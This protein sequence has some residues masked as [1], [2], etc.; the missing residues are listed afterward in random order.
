MAKKKKIFVVESCDEEEAQIFE[1]W[2][3][4]ETKDEAIEE[5]RRL[6]GE[7]AVVC[8]ARPLA[9]ERRAMTLKL[10]QFERA[11][12]K[13]GL[14]AQQRN[15]DRFLE[16]EGDLVRLNGKLLKLDTEEADRCGL[17]GKVFEPNGDSW[18]GLDPE[19]ADKV[20]AYMDKHENAD[21]EAAIV[22]LKS[23]GAPAQ[24]GGAKFTPYGVMEGRRVF[25]HARVLYVLRRGKY[26]VSDRANE[27]FRFGHSKSKWKD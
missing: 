11:L 3:P 12:L 2:V 15:W 14:E 18:G 24:K 25:E 16:E 7:Y 22:A 9:G 26:V 6:R 23:K 20:S 27:L 17:C 8:G 19:C 4:A 10:A 13:G 5:V 21:Q 1:D